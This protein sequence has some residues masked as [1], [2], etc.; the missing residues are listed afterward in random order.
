MGQLDGK[1]ALVTGGSRGI[2]AAIAKRLAADGA[3]VAIT[4]SGNAEAAKAT[5]AAMRARGVEAMALKA[6][7]RDA[8][9]I[10]GLVP[11]VIE[12]LG[13]LDILVNNAGI[14]SIAAL[15]ECTDEDFEAMVAVNVRA[16]FLASRAAAAVMTDGGRIIT[17]G[18]VSGERVP[19]TGGALYAMSKAAV[20]ALTKGWARDLGPRGITV[21]CVQPGPIDTDMNPASGDLADMLVP[22]T[23]IGR[24]GTAD[25]VAAVV[26]FLASP[27]SANVTGCTINVDGGFNT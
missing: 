20:A 10:K 6:D 2:G 25:E 18:S 24:Y 17:I 26:A 21:T 23:A 19:F 22:M 13:R 9:A 8:A 4:F 27:A 14:F 11:R 16:V 7:A 1:V 3:S 15:D 5:L 12:G